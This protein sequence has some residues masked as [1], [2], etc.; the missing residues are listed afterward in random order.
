[1]LG[2]VNR[3]Y[4]SSY[5]FMFVLGI[6]FSSACQS[7][8]S[9]VSDQI[10]DDILVKDAHL[11]IQENLSNEN[12]IILDTRTTGEYNKGHLRNSV[13]LDYS[14]SSFKAE[15]EKLDKNKK[16]LIYCRSGNRSKTTLNMM[17]KMDFIEAY[18]MVG[19]IKAWTK[20]GYQ[21]VN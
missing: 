21:L 14:S 12:F 9:T 8:D 10:S 13:F 16:Y 15:I 3:I 7:G 5:V 4:S 18:N 17:K 19:G 11:M 6:L 20:A 1:M 2:Q